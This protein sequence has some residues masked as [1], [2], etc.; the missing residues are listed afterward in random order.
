MRK[1]PE[2][3]LHFIETFEANIIGSTWIKS[4]A[5]K[6]DVDESLAKYDGEWAIESSLDSALEGDQGLVLK[7]KAKHHAIAAKLARPFKFNENKPLVVQ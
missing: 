5:K 6:D 2:G 1:V 3:S 7:S 4:K